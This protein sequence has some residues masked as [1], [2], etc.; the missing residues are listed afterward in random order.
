MPIYSVQLFDDVEPD[1]VQ[2]RSV[3]PRQAAEMYVDAIIDRDRLAANVVRVTDRGSGA[4]GV[5]TVTRGKVGTG[6]VG[7]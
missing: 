3:S 1:T 7:S 4:V 5:F 6:I 2:G